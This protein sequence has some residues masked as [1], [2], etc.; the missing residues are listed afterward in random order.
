MI[1][2]DYTAGIREFQYIQRKMDGMQK[3]LRQSGGTFGIA[4]EKSTDS[5]QNALQNVE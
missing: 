3:R 1:W 4:E 2:Q 5:F